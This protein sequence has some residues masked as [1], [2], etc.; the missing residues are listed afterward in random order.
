MRAP[1]ISRS[2]RKPQLDPMPRSGERGI[3]I[4]LVALAI[5]SII[6]MAGLSIDVGTLYQANAEAQRAA[7]AAAL[8]AARELSISGMTSDPTN[9]A[10]QWSTAC[11]AASSVAQSVASQNTVGGAAPSGVSVTFISGDQ[12]SDCT[13]GSGTAVS[14]GVN[15]TV[16]VQV[17]QANLPTFFARIWGR[18][19]NTVSASATAEAFNPSDSGAFSASASI[20]PVQPRCVKPWIIPNRDPLNPAPSGKPL[21]YCGTT[22]APSCSTFVG[23]GGANNGTIT[24][25]GILI[26]GGGTGVIGESFVLFANC[27]LSG[28]GPCLTQNP[29]ANITTIPPQPIPNLQYEPALVSSTPPVAIP[30]CG[31]TNAYQEAVA[32]CDQSTQYECGVQYNNPANPSP[33]E[34]DLDENPNGTNGDAATATECLINESKG[35]G[36]DSLYL[37]SYPYQIQAGAANALGVASNTVITTSPSVV[38]IP[39]YDDTQYASLS[40]N[41]QVTIVGFLQVFVQNVDVNHN[42]TLAVT[43]MNVAACGNSVDPTSQPAVYGSSPVP[44]RLITPP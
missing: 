23:S 43:V 9:S 21:T 6:A 8:A 36:Q 39:I 32:G 38:S 16:T 5:F 20:V 10:D 12:K 34:I 25:G 30:S 40:T 13:A 3:T 37:G 33:T 11:A 22:G 4:A 44:V 28:S 26:N 42:G 41:T 18:T 17:T 31:M 35:S 27:P 29:G 14:F 1:F 19:G 24:N 7:D 15:P 2:Q